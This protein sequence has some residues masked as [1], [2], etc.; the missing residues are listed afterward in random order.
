MN[1]NKAQ[2]RVD[3]AGK[4]ILNNTGDRLI[5]S[6]QLYVDL[7][8]FTSEE[9]QMTAQQFLKMFNSQLELV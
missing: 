5:H 6:D 2:F 4:T 1:V 7:Y 8:A 9:Q 3:N